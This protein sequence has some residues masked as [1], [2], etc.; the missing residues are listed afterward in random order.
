M[1]VFCM[2]TASPVTRF[3]SIKLSTQ[4]TPTSCNCNACYLCE[5]KYQLGFYVCTPSGASYMDV[6]SISVAIFF[7]C[8]IISDYK[9]LIPT[10]NEDLFV[11]SNVSIVYCTLCVSRYTLAK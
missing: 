5:K 2:S 11:G 1:L 6:V 8:T 9:L 7:Y 10:A 4:A 3:F